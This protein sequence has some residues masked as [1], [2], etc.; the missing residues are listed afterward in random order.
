[1]ENRQRELGK[2]GKAGRAKA[3]A[4]TLLIPEYGVMVSVH[5]QIFKVDLCNLPHCIL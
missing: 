4:P 2:K 1:M 5:R 3:T